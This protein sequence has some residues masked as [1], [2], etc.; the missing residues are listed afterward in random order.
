MQ[1]CP[2]FIR[3]QDQH[4]VDRTKTQSARASALRTRRRIDVTV[5]DR[6]NRG[7]LATR[8][9]SMHQ[10]TQHR[11]MVSLYADRQMNRHISGLTYQQ[12]SR[13]EQPWIQGRVLARRFNLTP[14][15]FHCLCTFA[16]H[17]VGSFE[18]YGSRKAAKR[19]AKRNIVNT[20]SRHDTATTARTFQPCSSH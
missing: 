14:C 17:A 10:G 16:H 3:C 9:W 8:A 7:T 2:A 12:R 18:H 19:A 6:K 11:E 5:L 20:H 1:R 15:F 4:L 13:Y